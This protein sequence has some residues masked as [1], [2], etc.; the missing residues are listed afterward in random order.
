MDMMILWIRSFHPFSRP[1]LTFLILGANGTSSLL[2]LRIDEVK[3]LIA[4][5]QGHV[6]RFDQCYETQPRGIL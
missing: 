5:D 6:W 3:A 4:D 2:S 1:H